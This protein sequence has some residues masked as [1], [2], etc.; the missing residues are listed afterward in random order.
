[1]FLFDYLFDVDEYVTSHENNK[2]IKFWQTEAVYT[3]QMANIYG[4]LK[5]HGYGL[6]VLCN[7]DKFYGKFN[8]GNPVNGTYTFENG[9]YC[10]VE[11]KSETK[12][13]YSGPYGYPKP[14]KIEEQKDGK[15]YY[16]GE[17][18][19]GKP[20]GIGTMKIDVTDWFSFFS[21]YHY[22]KGGFKNGKRHGVGKYT[23]ANGGYDVCVYNEG[24]EIYCIEEYDPKKEQTSSRVDDDTE[25]YVDYRIKTLID[26]KKKIYQ[27][28]MNQGRYKDAYSILRELDSDEVIGT[29][30]FSS[31]AK[32]VA[33]LKE[34]L[35]QIIKEENLNF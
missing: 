27:D 10:E 7:G 13:E 26:T 2:S 35:E 3:G 25:D 30:S 1:M 8:M 4:V 19:N 5:P 15:N 17:L 24:E 23:F 21:S 33:E 20:D 31:S 22:Y 6:A 32:T 29:N 28:Y 16:N 34:E 9:S 14:T 18:K 11:Y 12:F